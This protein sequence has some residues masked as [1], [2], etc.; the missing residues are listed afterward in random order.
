M[1]AALS[2]TWRLAMKRKSPQI[3]LRQPIYILPAVQQDS[4]AD[5]C[6]DPLAITVIFT[7]RAST[8]HAIEAAARLAEGL[9]ARIR[10][11]VPQV[12][13]YSLP[14]EKPSV[15]EEFVAHQIETLVG[16][17][18]AMVDIE[19]YYCR[20]KSQALVQAL[21]ENC[22]VVIGVR[23]R[24]WQFWQSGLERLLC[25]NGHQVLLIPTD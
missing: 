1:A 3:E 17:T 6:Q 23:K 24:W 5:F 15:S 16:L 22:L 9:K 14:L 4:V 13:P 7:N 20:R 25:R 12:V 2:F 8:F 18:T 11:V 10:L 21:D 19:I